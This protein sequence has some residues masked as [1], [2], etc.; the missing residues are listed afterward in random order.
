LVRA[1]QNPEDLLL[2]KFK[3]KGVFF[4]ETQADGIENAVLLGEGLV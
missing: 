4:G 3:V 1:A 2:T